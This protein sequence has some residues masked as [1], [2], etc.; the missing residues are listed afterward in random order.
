MRKLLTQGDPKEFAGHIDFVREEVDL[1]GGLWARTP[2]WWT[3]WDTLVARASAGVG[4]GAIYMARCNG[5]C[6][7]CPAEGTY[8]MSCYTCRTCIDWESEDGKRGMCADTAYEGQRKRKTTHR[9]VCPQY[10]GFWWSYEELNRLLSRVPVERVRAA[11]AAGKAGAEE[12]NEEDFR[13]FC[14]LVKG[15]ARRGLVSIPRHTQE[16]RHVRM[17]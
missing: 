3:G 10:R 16:D 11:S 15:L 17:A 6:D 5:E 8:C 12:F 2:A 1:E 4:I 13:E 14:E 7:A 9:H